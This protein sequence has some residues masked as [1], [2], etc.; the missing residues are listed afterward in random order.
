MDKIHLAG[1]SITD[2][3]VDMV[4]EVPKSLVD[5]K[6]MNQLSY[7]ALIDKFGKI[8]F[9]YQ[10]NLSV[11]IKSTIEKLSGFSKN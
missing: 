2:V 6:I 11:G 1:P 5:A 9:S 8:G 10:G 3:E 7:N 4:Y